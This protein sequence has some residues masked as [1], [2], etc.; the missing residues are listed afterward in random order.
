M[1]Y[2]LCTG[3]FAASIYCGSRD[4]V[5]EQQALRTGSSARA[6]TSEPEWLVV[7][8]VDDEASQR[9]DS[10]I[11]S[12]RVI[13]VRDFNADGALPGSIY[14]LGSANGQER[15]VLIA[16]VPSSDGAVVRFYILRPGNDSASV[17]ESFD[18]G[19]EYTGTSFGIRAR[20][21][22]DGDGLAD[23]IFCQYRR[24]FEK[25]VARAAGFRDGSWYEAKPVRGL[26]PCA[27]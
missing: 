20:E 4:P 15:Y 22:A 5:G 27:P 14:R 26:P 11:P 10:L 13:F 12:L 1:R 8:W 23:V 21:D 9:R 19:V 18:T 7:D 6:Q 24:D 16:P 17:I 3:T 2:L 25:G